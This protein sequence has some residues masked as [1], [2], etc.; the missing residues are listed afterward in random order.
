MKILGL[1]FFLCLTSFFSYAQF[2]YY[3]QG[4]DAYKAKDFAGCIKNLNEYMDYYTRDKSFDVDVHYYLALSYFKTQSFTSAVR[5]FDQALQLGHKNTGNIHWFMAKGYFELKAYK[6]SIEEYGK[7]LSIITDKP[8]Q[9][10]LYFERGNVYLKQ[11]DL[12]HAKEDYSLAMATDTANGDAKNALALLE[13][14]PESRNIVVPKKNEPKQEGKDEKKVKQEDAQLLTQNENSKLKKQNQDAKLNPSEKGHQNKT[15]DKKVEI[16]KPVIKPE[17]T[18]TQQN[19]SA[20][21]VV[22][23]TQNAEPT[24]A[25][26]YKNEKRYALVIGNSN[27]K[28]V[29]PLKNA[30]N[31]AND[32]ATEL[33]K[34]NFEVVKVINGSY[35]EM[36]EAYRKFQQQLSNGP[37]DQTIGLFYY[38]GHGLQNEGENYLV[39][40]E[41]NIQYEDDI[42]RMCFPVQRVV[43]ANMERSNTRMNIVILDACRNNPFPSAY[44]S[45]SAGLAEIQR[46]KGSFI[47]FST[48][49]G[50][51][52]SDGEGR[53][54]L[55]TQEL[56]KAMRKPGRTIEQVFKDV[57]LNVMKQSGEKQFTWDQSNI[58]GD[59]Y[60]KF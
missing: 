2:K 52:A 10:K 60:F 18:L 4:I 22:A 39:P 12:V 1:V 24:L 32:M 37:K 28:Y 58:I 49:P 27:Y 50:S 25:D 53:N 31:D 59:F 42:P 40:V 19:S 51:V 35:S 21:P 33:E 29:A 7:A 44:R 34:S 15:D 9:S 3:E 54:G 55:Y 41:A 8:N 36:R 56:L 43:V 16:E 45:G 48:A 30:A 20:P 5:E 38:A 17:A 13:P 23:P 6:E 26:E 14:K 46:A 11:N 47:A 57:R